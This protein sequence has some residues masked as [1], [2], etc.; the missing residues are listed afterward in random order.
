VRLPSSTRAETRIAEQQN[1]RRWGRGGEG[2]DAGSLRCEALRTSIPAPRFRRRG[3]HA[4]GRRYGSH[5]A[6]GPPGDSLAA[7]PSSVHRGRFCCSF[8]AIRQT[9]A[10]SAARHS[11]WSSALF[12]GR[13]S[14]PQWQSS[15]GRPMWQYV[16]HCM[17]L[18]LAGRPARGRLP[19]RQRGPLAPPA[20]RPL[21]RLSRRPAQAGPATRL[22]AGSIRPQHHQRASAASLL[23]RRHGASSR[24]APQIRHRHPIQHQCLFLRL[25]LSVGLFRSL[26]VSFGREGHETELRRGRVVTGD[27]GNGSDV[28]SEGSR[29]RK[30]GKGGGL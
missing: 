16:G 27:G 24:R 8:C 26:S 14:P 18:A 30:E 12:R 19:L 9:A 28:S 6:R 21:D 15:S 22:I 7:M 4:P 1:L 13:A 20:P 17:A 3:P 5:D 2:G 11:Q 29:R 25:R 23:R 10:L